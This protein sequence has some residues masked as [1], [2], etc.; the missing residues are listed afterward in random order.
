MSMWKYQMKIKTVIKNRN[1]NQ[2][3]TTVTTTTTITTT[4]ITQNLKN[5]IKWEKEMKNKRKSAHHTRILTSYILYVCKT[6]KKT[7]EKIYYNI[8][9]FDQGKIHQI[10]ERNKNKIE[11]D[12]IFEI[13]KNEIEKCD[14]IGGTLSK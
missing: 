12:D 4:P 3:I 11:T 10:K 6:K 14:W 1:V 13:K 9:A 8:L 7:W 5:K 2:T